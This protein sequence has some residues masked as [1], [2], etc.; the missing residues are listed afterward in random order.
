MPFF[1]LSPPLLLMLIWIPEGVTFPPERCPLRGGGEE[2]GG[3]EMQLDCL[4]LISNYKLRAVLERNTVTLWWGTGFERQ[5]SQAEGGRKV[6]KRGKRWWSICSWGV[7]CC[8]G[9]G[10]QIISFFASTCDLDLCVAYTVCFSFLIWR[11]KWENILL[12]LLQ[13]LQRLRQ[14]L[15]PCTHPKKLRLR[16]QRTRQTRFCKTS[17]R[18][19][20]SLPTWL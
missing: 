1:V 8:W 16:L 14:I 9:E 19:P 13:L 3:M 18:S 6:M 10:R 4:H 7:C 11:I 15:L 20:S 2:D 17:G 5:V 12:L